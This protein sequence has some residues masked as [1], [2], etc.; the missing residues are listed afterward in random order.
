MEVGQGNSRENADMAVR[1]GVVLPEPAREALVDL[2]VREYR[3]PRDQAAVLVL[4]GLRRR[5][6]LPELAADSPP[7]PGNEA[8]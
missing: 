2:A 3:D 8:A 6:L 5:R 4:E 7:G 1:I